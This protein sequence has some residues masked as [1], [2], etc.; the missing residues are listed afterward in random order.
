MKN[1]LILIIT[2]LLTL[3]AISAPEIKDYSEFEIPTGSFIPVISLQEFSTAYNDE[4]DVLKFIS[5]NDIYM[6]EHTILPKGAIFTGYIEKKNE[7]I[8]GT[9]ASMKIFINK[10]RLPDSTEL[11]LKG[12]IYHS[13][14][15]T[16]GGEMTDPETY[17]KVPHYHQGI[18]RHFKGVIQYRPGATRKMGEH[19]TIASGADLLV[20]LT[21]PIHMTR[22]PIKY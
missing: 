13:N 9:N 6:F 16:F 8:I 20:V 12:Y 3:P 18:A 14:N 11:P 7:P 1:L 2:F 19:V 15:N 5:T 21:A 22:I 17:I 10:M 4:T